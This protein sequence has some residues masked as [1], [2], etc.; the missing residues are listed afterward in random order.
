MG[1]DIWNLRFLCKAWQQG[2]DFGDLLQIDRQDIHIGPSAYAE[3]DRLFGEAQVPGNSAS[4]IAGRRWADDGLYQAFGASS[5][6]CIEPTGY[7]GAGIVHDLND[8]TPPSLHQ[9][10]DFIFD[11]GALDHIFN[12]P[13]ALANQ[14]A[15]LKVGGRI[16]AALPANNWLGHGFY[17]FGPDLPLSIF[18]AENGFRLNAV[19]YSTVHHNDLTLVNGGGGRGN[20]EIG[21]IG[22]NPSLFYIATKVAH[23]V[24]FRYW[25]RQNN[26]ARL[27]SEPLPTGLLERPIIRQRKERSWL[28]NISR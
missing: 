18:S 11:G 25:P 1:I 16:S 23:V 27:G 6:Q 20:L 4:L 9:R 15:M 7:N 21:S 13:A 10:F 3:A 5:V 26:A 2:G 8:P 17:Q 14:M 12:V 19:F 24:P 28:Q 22:A